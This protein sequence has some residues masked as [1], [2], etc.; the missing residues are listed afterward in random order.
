MKKT[1]ALAIAPMFLAAACA[2]GGP[3]T[4]VASSAAAAPAGAQYCKKDRLSTEGDALVCNWSTSMAEACASNYSS[5]LAKG[6]VRSGPQDASRCA[7]G[8]WLVTVTTK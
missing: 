6:A 4:S 7:N 5:S 2:T 1:L 8:Q 3:S